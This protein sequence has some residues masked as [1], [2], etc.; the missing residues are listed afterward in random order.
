MDVARGFSSATA[1]ATATATT[2]TTLLPLL[3]LL[4][5]P[6]P[7]A[8]LGVMSRGLVGIVLPRHSTPAHCSGLDLVISRLVV[9]VG[10]SS[11]RLPPRGDA[12]SLPPGR[13]SG[14][15]P[16]AHLL[17]AV[18]QARQALVGPGHLV[19]ALQRWS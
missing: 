17:L 5:F 16:L 13:R 15:P 2:T 11:R 19:R 18:L 12:L 4:L 8:A 6:V 7:L 3:L 1:A 10:A 9:V 14:A